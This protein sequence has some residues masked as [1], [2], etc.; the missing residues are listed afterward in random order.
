MG[1]T[2]ATS[3]GAGLP[4]S[5][6]PGVRHAIMHLPSIPSAPDHQGPL[7]HTA[8][9]PLS[10][11]RVYRRRYRPHDCVNRLWGLLTPQPRDPPCESSLLVFAIRGSVHLSSPGYQPTVATTSSST[12][13]TIAPRHLDAIDLTMPSRTTIPFLVGMMLLTGVCNTLLT[14]YQVS[15]YHRRTLRR[16]LTSPKG[17]P[18]RPQ[19][20]L[21]GPR[22]APRL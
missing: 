4:T 14:K 7:R 9:G 12:S 16:G 15:H 13:F 6:G 22:Q 1:Q 18:M 17:Q 21:P 2:D 19:L 5:L 10:A 8:S 20:R 11:P 3:W